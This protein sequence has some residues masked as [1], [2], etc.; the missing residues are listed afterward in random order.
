M[1]P[2]GGG[3]RGGGKYARK[4]CTQRSTWKWEKVVLK[5]KTNFKIKARQFIRVIRFAFKLKIALDC[6]LFDWTELIIRGA[7]ANIFIIPFDV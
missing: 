2:T 3:K 4:H 5:K 1:K 6:N 7:V